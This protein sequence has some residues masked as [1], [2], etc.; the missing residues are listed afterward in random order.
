MVKGGDS[1]SRGCEFES[2][3]QILDGIHFI[4]ISCTKLYCLIE[5][6]EINKKR[7]ELAHFENTILI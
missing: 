4:F 5:K 3:T 6:T 1:Q 7:P 2:W